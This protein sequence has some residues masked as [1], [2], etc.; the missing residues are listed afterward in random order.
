M[1]VKKQKNH[2]LLFSAL[3]SAFLCLILLGNTSCSNNTKP[4]NSSDTTIKIDGSTTVASL[5]AAMTAEFIKNKDSKTE[6]SLNSSSTGKGFQKFCQGELDIANASRPI[7]EKEI[8]ACKGKGIDF[9]E[10]PIAYGALTVVVNPGNTWVDSLKV[11][12]LRRMWSA[13]PAASP[14]PTSTTAATA[15][16]PPSAS[17]LASASP[18]QS[19]RAES[20]KDVRSDFP[21]VPLRLF[22]PISGSGNYDYF[23]QAVG[24]KSKF[25]NRIDYLAGD[26]DTIGRG[27]SSDQNALGYVSFPYYVANKDKVK[28]VPID[29]GK[30]PVMPSLESIQNSTY[31]PFSHLLFIYV[32]SKSLNK[33]HVKNFVD[34]YIANANRVSTEQK[35]IPLPLA[36]YTKVNGRASAKRFGSVF[37]QE[38][39]EGL[40]INELLKKL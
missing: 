20:W 13:P 12:D 26:Y 16:P 17:P 24:G 27:I 4:V 34:Y 37:D 33:P 38:N 35:Y 39:A 9:L 14:S 11:A 23:S 6:I 25:V 19:S 30:G 22:G 32:S 40:G 7:Q 18:N 21:E 8:V 10:L 36:A 28:A 29:A 2:A 31:R 3:L 15:S 1:F 5:T